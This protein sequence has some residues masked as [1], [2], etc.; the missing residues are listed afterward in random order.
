MRGLQA[1]RRVGSA[2]RQ[3][4]TGPAGRTVLKDLI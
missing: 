3:V 2:Y 4:F 1:M